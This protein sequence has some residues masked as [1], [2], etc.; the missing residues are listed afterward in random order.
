MILDE[1]GFTAGMNNAVKSWTLLM[2]QSKEK[3]EMV[4]VH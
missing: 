1:S 4:A 2:K 3:V